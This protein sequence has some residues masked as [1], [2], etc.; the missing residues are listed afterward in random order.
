[1]NPAH[2]NPILSDAPTTRAFESFG[3][4][5]WAHTSNRRQLERHAEAVRVVTGAARLAHFTKV[6]KPK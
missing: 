5:G 1:M 3:P 6:A 4:S 2:T